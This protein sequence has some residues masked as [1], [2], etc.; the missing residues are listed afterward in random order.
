MLSHL[1][2]QGSFGTHYSC[3]V[4][5]YNNNKTKWSSDAIWCGDISGK[6]SL[7]LWQLSL[8]CELLNV[9]LNCC[10]AWCV[11]MLEWCFVFFCCYYM[12]EW[13]RRAKFKWNLT[14]HQWTSLWYLILLTYEAWSC[15]GAKL[16][17]VCLSDYTQLFLKSNVF[18]TITS[19]LVPS[20]LSSF[21]A[22]QTKPSRDER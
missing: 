12:C 1:K 13:V 14:A 6:L 2:I 17:R 9:S 7:F 19:V 21:T 18:P 11:C 20:R 4:Y 5:I 8:M 16:I 3:D 10:N 22:L 15:G